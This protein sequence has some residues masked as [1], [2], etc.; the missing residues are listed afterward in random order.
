MST[1]AQTVLMDTTSPATRAMDMLYAPTVF[2]TT[3]IVQNLVKT[4]LSCG[5]T[6]KV[7]AR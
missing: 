1:T 6:L 7:D 2:Y 4:N 5:T 3:L